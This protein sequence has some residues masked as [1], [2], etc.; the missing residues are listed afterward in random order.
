MM[1]LVGWTAAYLVI[2]VVLAVAVGKF[3]KFGMGEKED[4]AD[5][6]LQ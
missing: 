3:I 4:G 5:R 6:S 2:A 1:W